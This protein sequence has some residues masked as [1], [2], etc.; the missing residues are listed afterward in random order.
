MESLETALQCYDAAFRGGNHKVVDRMRRGLLDSLKEIGETYDFIPPQKAV[1]ERVEKAVTE[2][3]VERLTDSLRL[4][5]MLKLD[6]GQLVKDLRL[7]K[8]KP[9]ENN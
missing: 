1:I 8:T 5:C 3:T 6:P 7:H 9:H 4:T 2:P